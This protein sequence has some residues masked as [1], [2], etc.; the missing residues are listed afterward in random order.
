[1]L[2]LKH[3]VSTD[4]AFDSAWAIL[5]DSFP[6]DERRS[7]EAHRA[8]EHDERYEF[9]AILSDDAVVG[10]VGLWRFPRVTVVEH[11]AIAPHA[12]SR[13]I[14]SAIIARLLGSSGV[15]VV[16]E[17]E[18]ASTG[19]DAALRMR[20]YSKLGFVAN[21]CAYRQPA[22]D[23]T[24]NPVEMVLMTHPTALSAPV[25]DGIKDVLYTEIYHVM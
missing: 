3:I 5:N 15:P 6:A 24:K 10:A 18:P 23:A 19:T 25:L 9:S 7:L 2:S 22:Y 12:R 4:D 11:I 14:G 20:F 8:I 1:V 16:I 13:G 17:V 21:D